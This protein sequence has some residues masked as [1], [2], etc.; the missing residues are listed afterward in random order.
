MRYNLLENKGRMDEETG[1]GIV[2]ERERSSRYDLGCT[3]Q[4]I[5]AF[6]ESV[7]GDGEHAENDTRGYG[8]YGRCD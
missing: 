1:A 8:F 3:F 6:L 7:R 5:S 2:S 4:K